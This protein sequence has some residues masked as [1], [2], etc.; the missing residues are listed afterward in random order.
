[1]STHTAHVTPWTESEE[2]RLV[3]DLWDWLTN[4][5]GRSC[6]YRAPFAKVHYVELTFRAK[7]VA[8]GSGASAREALADALARAVAGRRS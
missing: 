7:L 4:G 6:R 1:M 8:R 5:D 2:P 3:A